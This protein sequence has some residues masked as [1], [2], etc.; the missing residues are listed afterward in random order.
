MTPIF[1]PQLVNGP[2]GDPVLYIDFKFT[3]RALLFDL[4]DIQALPARKLLR[5]THIFVSHTHMD[6]F[7]G[8]DHLLRLCIG[9]RKSLALFG[10]AGFIAQV[11]HR[12]A[13]Y[14][15][16]L[17]EGYDT[18]LTLEVTEVQSSGSA[19]RAR[20]RC[21]ARFQR[22]QQTV[23]AL[24][25]GILLDEDSLRVRSALLDHRIPSLAF[26]LEEKT[27]INVWKNQLEALGLP[28][29]AWLGALKSAVRRGDPDTA[30][31][32][33]C[34]HDRSG[35][36]ER[37]LPLG[38]LKAKILH[39]VPGQ[40]IAYVVDA[41]GNTRNACRILG[42]AH[43]ADSLFIEAMF[44]HADAGRAADKYHLTARQAGWLGRMAGVRHLVPLHFSPRYSDD[45]QRLQQEAEAEFAAGAHGA[46]SPLLPVQ[47]TPAAD[48]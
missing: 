35:R 45:P 12:L 41:I 42:L 37:V 16:N 40:K 27:H 43:A 38:V 33:L 3:R 22:E 36:R 4:G 21:R 25:D 47:D 34:W 2:F 11:E 18:D 17:V 30:P 24:S 13:G 23:L 15:W 1:H 5:L 26:A 29:G 46:E 19:L 9:R 14:T 48:G 39:I 32:T 31:I 10:P 8:F 44:L 6:H 20:F 28:T 7:I